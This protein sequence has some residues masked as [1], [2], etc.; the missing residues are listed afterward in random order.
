MD[1]LEKEK[2]SNLIQTNLEQ[3]SKDL[4]NQKI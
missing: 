2:H 1:K 4:M 3:Y